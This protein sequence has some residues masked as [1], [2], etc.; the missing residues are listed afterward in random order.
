MEQHNASARSCSRRSANDMTDWRQKNSA[1]A[2]L[3]NPIVA[4]NAFVQ[5]IMMF[6]KT[7]VQDS[8]LM[9]ELHP[10]I[11][12][13]DIQSSLIQPICHSKGYAAIEAQE[14]DPGHTLLQQRVP[15][16]SRFQTPI[17]YKILFCPSYYFAPSSPRQYFF[18]SIVILSTPRRQTN[19]RANERT[20][21]R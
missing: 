16:R 21:E 6:R 4:E 8:V 14:H 17:G 9:M 15:M 20:N 12:F 3:F 18:A 13:G 11:P 5:V 2:I 10:A 1:L 19:E 7:F